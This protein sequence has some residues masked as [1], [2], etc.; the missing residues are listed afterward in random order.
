MHEG[1]QDADGWFNLE[2][3][4]NQNIKMP[5][6][7]QPRMLESN[8]SHHIS[9]ALISEARLGEEDEELIQQSI[10]ANR[11]AIERSPGSPQQATRVK[12]TNVG[13]KKVLSI[14]KTLELKDVIGR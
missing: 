3:T 2:H 14:G 8:P 6:A 9:P 1:D 10:T 11:P 4:K 7:T 12:H 5:P 13:K